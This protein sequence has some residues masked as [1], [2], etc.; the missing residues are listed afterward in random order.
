MPTSD[1]LA[2][3]AARIDIDTGKTEVDAM[4]DQLIAEAEDFVVSY[5]NL[6]RFPYLAQGT[7]VSVASATEDISG[8]ANNTLALSIDGSGY[9][10]IELTLASCTTGALTAGELQTQIRAAKDATSSHYW[11]WL[12]ASVGFASTQY[13]VTSPTYGPSS[14]VHVRASQS[15][16]K[17]VIGALGLS[18][19]YGGV[20]LPGGSRDE[21][22]E[23]VAARIA[24]NA[25]RVY[26][27]RPEAFE[28]G[29]SFAGRQESKILTPYV[30]GVLENKRGLRV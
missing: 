28:R 17:E 8:L 12:N 7:S 14:N 16:E 9:E 3:V 24:V 11:N 15:T 6:E 4:V 27:L 10:E 22:L 25:Y 30:M 2:A 29:S 26:N 23:E 13:T 21:Q 20:E 5:L 19:E 1:I 18:P